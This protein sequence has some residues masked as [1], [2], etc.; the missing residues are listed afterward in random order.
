[1]KRHGRAEDAK[2]YDREWRTDYKNRLT[3]SKLGWERRVALAQRVASYLVGSVLDLGCGYG[4]LAQF[5]KAEY[6]GIDFSPFV[7]ERA[8][9]MRPDRRFL[10]GDILDLPDVGCFDTVSMVETL[11]HM[12]APGQVLE[13]VRP[14]ARKR[15]VISV[16]KR[17]YSGTDPHCHVW[18]TWLPQDVTDLLGNGAM[19]YDFRRWRIGILD[20]EEVL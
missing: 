14:L 8:R 13:L 16:P 10:V 5:V 6:L 2:F 9:E 17:S 3:S 11:E 18:P 12:D 19:C 20:I 1:M 15:I 4:E 7:I